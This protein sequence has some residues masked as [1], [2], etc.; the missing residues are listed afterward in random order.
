MK[1]GK[2]ER[3]EIYYEKLLKLTNSLQ[4]KT[5]NDFLIIVLKYGL[6]P[7]LRVATKWGCDTLPIR[8]KGQCPH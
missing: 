2:N 3:M 7:D 8:R 4:H 1:W 5:T 6:Q